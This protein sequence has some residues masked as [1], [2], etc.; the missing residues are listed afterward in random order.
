M[1]QPFFGTVGKPPDRATGAEV[2]G[3]WGYGAGLSGKQP[4]P[5]TIAAAPAQR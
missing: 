1:L 5:F 4:S 3:P 2:L